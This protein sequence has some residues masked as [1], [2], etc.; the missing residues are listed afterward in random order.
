MYACPQGLSP[1]KLIN[2]VKGGL[3]ANGVKPDSGVTASDVEK[4]REYRKVPVNRLIARLNVGKY[5]AEAPLDNKVKET[6]EVKILTSQHIGAAALPC[7]KQGDFVKTGEVVARAGDGLSV[8][9][10]SSIDG[11]VTDVTDKFI[12]IRASR[13]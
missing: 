5:E 6:S 3:R 11:L 7:V 4:N 2:L 1:R 13:G 8:N 12:T 10:H 9:I